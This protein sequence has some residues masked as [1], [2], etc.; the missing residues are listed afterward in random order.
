MLL[1][2]ISEVRRETRF[3]LLAFVI[4]PYHIHI[5]IALPSRVSLSRVMRLIKGRFAN[6]Y[7]RMHRRRG[8]VWQERYHEQ[9]LRGERALM[10][11]IEY[12][13][14]NPVEAGLT[15]QAEFFAWSSANSANG[16]DLDAYLG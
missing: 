11:A 2:V 12:V 15:G 9:A 1:Q 14:A 4:M 6:R 8:C 3:H 16:T 10:A 13:Y 5:V 7:N